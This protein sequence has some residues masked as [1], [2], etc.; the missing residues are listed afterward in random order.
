MLLFVS[1]YQSFTL[2]TNKTKGKREYEDIGI[3]RALVI[4]E[5]IKNPSKIQCFSQRCYVK[6]STS[7]AYL[8]RIISSNK[9]VLIFLIIKWYLW[10]NFPNE[11]STF[12]SLITPERSLELIAAFCCKRTSLINF[13]N[14]DWMFWALLVINYITRSGSTSSL[15]NALFRTNNWSNRPLAWALEQFVG[16]G[17]LETT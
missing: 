12:R 3:G 16:M 1:K 5:S 6:N 17:A 15:I 7:F 2:T 9:C 8:P 4:R 10:N 14:C 13:S 11:T